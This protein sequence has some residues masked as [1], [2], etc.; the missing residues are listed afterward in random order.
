MP[1]CSRYIS[2]ERTL[3]SPYCVASMYQSMRFTCGQP[4][5]CNLTVVHSIHPPDYKQLKRISISIGVFYTTLVDSEVYLKLP[6]T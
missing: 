3:T 4:H 6:V 5:P 1:S 2:E